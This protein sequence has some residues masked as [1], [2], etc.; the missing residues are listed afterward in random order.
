[1]GAWEHGSMDCLLDVFI[2][3]R[4]RAFLLV[5]AYSGFNFSGTRWS[6]SCERPFDHGH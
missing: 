4:V 2:P 3:A 1:M 5:R 6:P